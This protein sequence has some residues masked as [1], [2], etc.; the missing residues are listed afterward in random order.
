MQLPSE[1]ERRNLYRE[2]YI[3]TS[4]RGIETC[5]CVVCARELMRAEGGLQLILDLK[6]VRELFVPVE[7]HRAHM[8]HD[9]MLLVVE[10]L[11]EDAHGLSG[12][13]CIECMRSLKSRRQPRL[14]LGNN[15]WIGNVPYQLQILTIPEQ[16]LIA[17]HHPRC[18]VFKLYPKDPDQD[19]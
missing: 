3:T 5:I 18:F 15:M 19:Y 4:N 17:L 9:G 7:T 11:R 16:L 8:L 10:C 6:V 14:S 12:W 2:F 1:Q 13:I